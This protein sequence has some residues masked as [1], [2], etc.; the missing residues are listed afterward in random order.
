MNRRTAALFA[1]LLLALPARA[2]DAEDAKLTAFFKTYLDAEFRQ[3]PLTATQL[4]DHR[5]DHLL[6]DL[7]PQARAAWAERTRKALDDLPRQ[8]D[9]QKL[10][11]PG[12]IDY[13]ILRH[14]LTY[15][16]WLAE[17]T[18]PFEQDP[19]TYNDYISDS[20]FLL[21]T[22]STLPKERNVRNAAARMA[23]IP[24]VVAAAKEGLRNPPRVFVE[25]AIRQNRGAIAYYESGIFEAAGE[26]A[27]LS[28]LGPPAKKVVAALKEY[29]Q[30]LEKDLLPRSKGDWRIGKE[31]FCKKLELELDA[32][33]TADEVLKEAETEF[34]RVE[35]EMY[36]VA[37]QLWAQAYP[38]KPL[39]PD[40]AEGRRAAITQVLARYNRDH[41]K[42]EDLVKDARATVERVKKFIAAKDILRLPEPDRCRVIEMPE[43]QR[44]NTIAY[45]NPSPPLDPKASSHYAV[46]PPPRD[47]DAR[48]VASF[49]E[50][51]N[52]HMLQIL[53]IHEG[54]PGHYVQLEYSNR[55]PSF[56]RRVLQSGVFAE[57]WAVYTEQMM[58]DQG[59]GGGS[60]PLRLNQLKFYLRAV[61]NAILDHRMHCGEWT[62][63]QALRFLTERAFQSE[64]EARLKVIRAKQSSCQLSTYFVGRTA[65][66]R[67]RQKVQ[68]ELGDRFELG[69]Y[70]EAVL[71]HGT[72]PVKYLPELVAARLKEPR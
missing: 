46:S 57:G 64:G 4:G 2:A 10:S 59:Y 21:L 50:E 47:W 26:P 33:L 3:R 67:L 11:R 66:C 36:V 55:H 5:F 14:H 9:Y 35:R 25:T 45:L 63:E 70:H 13:E 41:G 22:Q 32:G 71:A 1:A 72:L 27:Q 51:Y 6:D 56:I 49:M 30:F 53:T 39:P 48:R 16:L 52:A 8:V 68:R 58:L 18:K 42:V 37:R 43:F 60:L 29:Q 54:Y 24:R 7:S 65:F 61:A 31:K 20:T 44:G 40:D 23:F 17:N 15:S 19:R 69:R 28:E 38:G 12:Q 62:D 34:A